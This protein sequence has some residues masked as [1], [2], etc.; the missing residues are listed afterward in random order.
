MLRFVDLGL[1]RWQDAWSL[2]EQ[3]HERV[4]GGEPPIVF[5]VEHPP[6]IT[7]GR[8]V[9]VARRSLR[10]SETELRAAG[11]DV[12]ETDR[13]G[14]VTLHAPGQLVCY[15]ILRLN[16]FRLTVGGYVKLL[17]HA[18]IN[19]IARCGVHGRLD[20]QAVGVWVRDRHEQESKVCAI[21]VRVRR[22]V[23][24]HGFALNVETDLSLFDAIVPCGISDRSVT[25][26]RRLLGVQSPDM[27]HVK[28]LIKQALTDRLESTH[29][30]PLSGSS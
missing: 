12:V 5:L 2:Q 10:Y 19:A 18:V 1:M 20:P 25:S 30:I 4:L 8:Q 24:L 22:G 14:N 28:W 6:V 23:T 17:E 11:Y 13:G 16:Q 26:L 15:P 21:G 27:S 7:L 3:A 9:D 29:G